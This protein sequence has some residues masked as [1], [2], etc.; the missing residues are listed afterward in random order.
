MCHFS[1]HSSFTLTLGCCFTMSSSLAQ[2][3]QLRWNGTSID[4]INTEASID[5]VGCIHTTQG[6][7]LNK[8]RLDFFAALLLCERNKSAAA[9][10]V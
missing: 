2:G 8:G 3:L 10:G 1:R 7:D 6:Y 9:D 4:W 5:E